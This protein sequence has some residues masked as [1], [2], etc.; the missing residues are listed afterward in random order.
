MSGRL[1]S[2]SQYLQGGDNVKVEEMF[3]STQKTFTY[4]Y[5]S[6]VSNYVFEADYQPIVIDAMTYNTNDGQPNFTSSSVLGS[7]ANA[8]IAGSN[9]VTTDASSGLIKF[10]IPAQRYTGPLV[11]D[12]R[13]NVVI[14][15]V[16]FKWTNQ[17]V[18]PNTTESHRWAIIERYE[19]DVAI[20][21]PTLDGGFTA[22]PTS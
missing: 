3:P 20:G 19:P 13:T 10:T 21:N 12:A 16:S 2:F 22:I 8:E 9:I 4:N 6:D 1:L 14:S 15:V 5:G 17:G 18:T 11:P 7:F